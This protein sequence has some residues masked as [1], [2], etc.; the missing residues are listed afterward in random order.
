MPAGYQSFRA[1]VAPPAFR[2]TG[3][4]TA[5]KTVPTEVMSQ[6]CVQVSMASEGA[7][8]YN[9]QRFIAKQSSEIM[10]VE[11]LAGN[12]NNGKGKKKFRILREQ[13]EQKFLSLSRMNAFP[14]SLNIKV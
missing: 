10:S 1:A 8:R 13:I 9:C 6:K 14:Y 5:A 7:V 11:I 2:W 3:I 4:V 12:V